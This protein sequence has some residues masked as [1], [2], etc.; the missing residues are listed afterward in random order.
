MASVSVRSVHKSFDDVAVIHGVSI[1]ISDGEFLGS[2]RPVGLRQVDAA[3][4]DRRPRGH[5]RRRDRDRRHGGQRHGAEGPRRR[6]GVSELRPLPAHD[7]APEH[8]LQPAP[9][10]G[11]QE[12]DPRTG[13]QRRP[14][15]GADAAAQPAAA[16]A[17]GRRASAGGHGARHRARPAGVPLRRAAL[18]PRRQ[19]PRADADRDQGAAPAGS[20][21]PRSTSP[22]TRSRR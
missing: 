22:T 16:P 3:Q 4:D 2:R 6:H 20:G 13:G 7:G 1:D 12:H 8:G 15:P 5:Q 9:T 18:Q 21:P 17:L 10:P 19:A 14:D 11:R